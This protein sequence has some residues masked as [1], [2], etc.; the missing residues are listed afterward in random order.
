[1]WQ[2]S[3]LT[4]PSV[5]RYRRGAKTQPTQLPVNKKSL[6]YIQPSPDYCQDDPKVAQICSLPHILQP[7]MFRRG[8]SG[9]QGGDV[10][11]LVLVETAVT[12]SA[13][14]EDT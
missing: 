8:L 3:Q 2:V 7:P 12:F 10:T 4:N 1:M 5:E 9:Q 11:P 14:V 13:V 6:V